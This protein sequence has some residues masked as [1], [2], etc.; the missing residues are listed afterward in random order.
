MLDVNSN[1]IV[2]IAGNGIQGFRDDCNP[3]NAMLNTPYAVWVNS[4]GY[5]F[6]ADYGNNRIRV[7][8]NKV[9][10]SYLFSLNQPHLFY[11]TSVQGTA[12]GKLYVTSKMAMGNAF[13]KHSS[14]NGEYCL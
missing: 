1:I 11:P 12:T 8:A 4:K 7:V 13:Y 3:L 14:D 2:T 5:V 10:S 6:I 9:I